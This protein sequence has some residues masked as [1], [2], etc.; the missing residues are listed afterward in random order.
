MKKILII[1]PHFPPSNLAAV[2][3]SRLFAQH[4]PAFGWQPVIL[5][6]HE[7]YYEEALDHNLA[8]LLP[9]ELSIEKVSAFKVS[10]P[11]LIGDIGLRAFFQ[12]YKRAKKIIREQKID[13]LYIPIPSFYVALLGRWLHNSTGVRYGID[14]IDPWVHNFPGSNKFFSRHWFSTRLSGLLEPIAIRKASLITGVAEG[15]YK[16]VQERNLH[17]AGECLFGAMPYG[18]EKRDHEKVKE[19][20]LH[21]YLFVQRPGKLQL[22]YAGAMLPK[23]YEPLEKILQAIASMP[24]MFE[25]LEIHFIGTGK[26][27]DDPEGYNIKPLAEK[28][29][30]WQK[31]IFEY[32]KRIPYLDV[33]V[34]LNMSQGVLI[35]G[36]TEMHYTPSKVFQGI[37]SGKPLLAVLHKDS[38]ALQVIESTGAGICYPIDPDHLDKLVEGFN[39]TYASY[40]SWIESFQPAS[41]KMEVFEQYSAFSITNTLAKLLDRAYA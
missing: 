20:G 2:H 4:L 41:V 17:L 27:P 5:T 9:E 40:I 34:H 1:S 18:G 30:L 25:N 32:P 16:G 36:S 7:E 10:R 37:L 33:L 3:R 26:T 38:T 8:K 11:R 14:Y 23:A 29:G 39:K 22:V 19:L 15:Y 28:Y 31:V 35:L 6:V 24:A 21:P 12:L 13:F